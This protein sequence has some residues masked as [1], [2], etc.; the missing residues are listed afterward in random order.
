M[1][2]PGL[3]QQRFATLIRGAMETTNTSGAEL[4]RRTGIHV[5]TISRCRDP[6][7]P[8]GPPALKARQTLEA[9]MG[10]APGSLSGAPGTGGHRHPAQS[11]ALAMLEAVSNQ[12]DGCRR[13][14]EAIARLLGDT[15]RVSLPAGAD[16]AKGMPHN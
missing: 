4:H 11:G 1:T 14:I 8:S 5:T 13:Q 10:L 12:L 6:D 9:A 15:P 7:Y 16:P 2:R 3:T